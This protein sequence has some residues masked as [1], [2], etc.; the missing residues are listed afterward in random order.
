MDIFSKRPLFLSCML[1]LAF[2]TAGY[3]MNGTLKAAISI[4]AAI[5]LILCLI[6]AA[7]RYH[8]NEKKNAFLTLILCLAM[9]VLAIAS[10][11]HYY[12][13]SY[14]K[15]TDIYGT[16]G[17][18]EAT[19]AAV[20]YENNFS[21]KYEIHVN[22]FN[23][24]EDFKA[25]LECEYSGAL[26]VGDRIAVN[27]L[28]NALPQNGSDKFSERAEA[29]SKGIFV[30]LTSDE[31]SQLSIIK[32]TEGGGAETAFAR[33]NSRLSD[34]LT[35]KV[36]GEMGRLS[37]ALLL[38]NKSLL[39]GQTER[40]FRRVGA[41]HILA[42]SGMH[43]SIIMGFAM[44]LLRRIFKN[45]SIVIIILSVFALFYLALT[46][47]SISATRSVIMLLMVYIAFLVSGIPDSLT[48]LSVAGFLI[49]FL[50]PGAILDAGFWM[51]FSATLGILVYV[52]ALNDMF[53]NKLEK[54]ESKRELKIRKFIYSIISA[55]AT[56]FAALIPLIIVMC[57][58]IKEISVLSVLSSLAL[59]I[60]TAIVIILSLLL[61]PLASVPYISDVIVWGI[62]SAAGLMLGY[63][64]E[65]SDL[66][67]IVFS[68]N[69]PFATLM[70]IIL[71]AALLYSFA[72]RHKR[73]FTSLIP[74]LACLFVFVGVMFFYEDTNKDN[75]NVS[76]INAST[77]SDI[78]VLSD[79]REV[80]ICDISNGSKTSY[81]LALAE[82]FEVRATEIK[83]I[84]LT[85]YTNSHIATFY[86][87]FA[88]NKVRAVWAPYPANEDEQDKLE[89]LY[90]VAKQNGVD[91]YVYKS[92]ER[93]EPFENIKIEH[94]RDYIERSVV[95][96]DLLC[97]FT[98]KESL[99]YLS[100]AY[101]ES[102][103]CE[104]AQYYLSRSRYVIFGDRGPNVKTKYG[105]DNMDKIK[106]IA[107]AN[108]E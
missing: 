56:C 70:S 71:G 93:L 62:R 60:P 31:E 85:R 105:I 55:I 25:M 20:S 74:F 37:S 18:A 52:S 79:E 28:A 45:R 22:T 42:L 84:L 78:I 41:S 77:K 15:Y 16:E 89:R 88:E 5:L 29:I 92:G 54:C 102:N 3:F 21:S 99:T 1:F 17:M 97:I 38:G 6:L 87:I 67:N 80:V 107:F 24:Q 30:V 26:R 9:I 61:L 12:D 86:S 63:C 104:R 49:V 2:A 90:Y 96:I 48:A 11:I 81:G 75:L 69:Y 103:L 53:Q 44:L 100:P 27:V 36:G 39:S 8:S 4:V 34:I 40:D 50:S 7:F 73:P 95:P 68:L 83:A 13:V 94:S 14:E 108:K 98:G 101:N 59:S 91:V 65:F 51:S 76:Y 33:L 46:G 43:M 57:I 72:S 32:Y 47:F 64:T 66:E 82:V 58:F 23:G 19:V 106:T 10:S 35:S